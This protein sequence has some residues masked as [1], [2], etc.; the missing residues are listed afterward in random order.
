MAILGRTRQFD[1]K[2]EYWQLLLSG[3]GTGD[4]CRM[5]GISRRAGYRR[6]AENG[7]LP[8]V[9]TLGRMAGSEPGLPPC[10]HRLALVGC[11]CSLV[12]STRPAEMASSSRW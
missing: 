11:H 12:A 6:R 4:A 9:G 2:S 3:I 7:G 10:R 5:A 1:T 8:P